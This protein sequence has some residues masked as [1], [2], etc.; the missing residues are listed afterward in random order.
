MVSS[1]SGSQIKQFHEIPTGS[2]H[3]GSLNTGDGV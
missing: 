3:T 2:P 1:P